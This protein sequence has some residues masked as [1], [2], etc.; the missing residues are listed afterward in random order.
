MPY[1][2]L[3]SMKYPVLPTSPVD[4]VREPL[5]VLLSKL[6][7]AMAC[8]P[9]PESQV[10]SPGAAAPT[11]QRYWKPESVAS[12]PAAI[13]QLRSS[14]PTVDPAAAASV[15]ARCAA[16]IAV[17]VTAGD[18]YSYAPTAPVRARTLQV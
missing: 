11:S 16:V 8:H 17:S 4:S 3:S 5:R 2:A 9:A 10:P 18:E 13:V 7:R 12:Y 6:E 14:A 1:T 15:G